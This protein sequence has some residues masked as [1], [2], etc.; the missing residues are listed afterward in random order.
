[1]S[2]H[3]DFRLRVLIIHRNF[4]SIYPL[5]CMLS[6]EAHNVQ[7]LAAEHLDEATR[8]IASA[9]FHLILVDVNID[10]RGIFHVIEELES[11]A[12]GVPTVLLTTDDQ[13]E[14]AEKM[15]KRGF[16]DYILCPSDFHPGIIKRVL[17]YARQILNNEEQIAKLS[18]FDQ[19]TGVA[20]RYL[21]R[22]RLEHAVIRSQREQKNVALLLLDIN[23]FHTINDNYGLETGDQILVQVAE[24]LGRNLRKQ[25]TIA[26]FGGDEFSLILENLADIKDAGY[27]AQHLLDLVTKPFMFGTKP[28]SITLSIGIAIGAPDLTYDP[29]TLLKQ[30]DIARYRAKEKSHSDFQYFADSLNEAIHTDIGIGRNLTDALQRIFHQKPDSE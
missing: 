19:L 14:N 20:N 17:R 26:R 27:I 11:H 2:Q 28:I 4:E 21:F 7:I 5:S 16:M 3:D 6:D 8:K 9:L 24:R 1:M 15:L 13:E 23:Q 29:A 25:D 12:P 18:H 10:R 30:A 22:D